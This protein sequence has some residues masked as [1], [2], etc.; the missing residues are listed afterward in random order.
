MKEC[1]VI[2]PIGKEGSKVREHADEVFDHIIKPA[3]T[4][5]KMVAFRSDQLHE[6]GKISEQMFNKIFAADLCIAVLTGKN[7]NV[8]YE[9]AVAHSAEQPVIVLIDKS[10]EL[11]FDVQDFRTVQYDLSITSFK[12]K[13]Y[14]KEVVDQINNLMGAGWETTNPFSDFLPRHSVYL[15]PPEADPPIDISD[16]VW[17]TEECFILT[18]DLKE[19]VAFKPTPGRTF[20]AKIPRELR[21]KIK[22]QYVRFELKD[23]QGNT[24]QVDKFFWFQNI[25]RLIKPEKMEVST[26][27][28]DYD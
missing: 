21:K 20:E 16:I 4:K 1:F 6:P 28:E 13:T 15:Y 25:V 7:P 11:P 18:E 19:K 8:Y 12:K 14:I 10:E 23:N 24:W 2:S 3:M 22:D 27:E 5:C 26:A 9:L 17:N